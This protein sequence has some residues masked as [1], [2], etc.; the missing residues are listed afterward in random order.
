MKRAR[1]HLEE[2]RKEPDDE[3][4]HE[5][6]VLVSSVDF[7]QDGAGRGACLTQTMLIQS[8]KVR[9]TPRDSFLVDTSP[10]LEM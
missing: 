9:K 10:L 3:A 4:L 1:A 5:R 8:S 6:G 2:R 7:G